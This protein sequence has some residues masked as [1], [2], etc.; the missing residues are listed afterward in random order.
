M[1]FS[2]LKSNLSGVTKNNDNDDISVIEKDDKKSV[3]DTKSKVSRIFIHN[4]FTN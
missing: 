4:T 2:I 3:P 1:L